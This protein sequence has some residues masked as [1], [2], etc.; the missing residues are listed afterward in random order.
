MFQHPLLAQQL[1]SNL[2]GDVYLLSICL[3]IFTAEKGGEI[4]REKSKIKNKKRKKIHN[5]T[6]KTCL[7]VAGTESRERDRLFLHSGGPCV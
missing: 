1:L 6:T 5:A 2:C 7:F 4:K 3:G